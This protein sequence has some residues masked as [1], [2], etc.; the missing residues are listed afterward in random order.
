MQAVSLEYLNSMRSI[1]RDRGYMR[2][3]F[4]GE[5]AVALEYASII[6]EH[7]PYSNT[8]EVFNNGLDT[9]I[10]GTLEQD[11]LKI[12][13]SMYFDS[14]SPY[15]YPVGFIGENL[16]TTGVTQ[17]VDLT[18]GGHIVSIAVLS[19][20][21]GDNYPLNFSITDSNGNTYTYTNTTGRLVTITQDFNNITGLTLTATAMKND[22]S[23]LRIYSICFNYSF[24]YQNDKIIDSSFES[25]MSPISEHLPQINFSVE[26]IHENHEYDIENPASILT[27]FDRNT[28]VNVQYG[29]HLPESNTIE[30]LQAAKLYVK[31]WSVGQTSITINA[32][33]IL[34]LIDDK[35]YIYGQL[36]STS[37]YDLA[38]DLFAELGISNYDID[39]D[40]RE[41]YTKNPIPSETCKEGLQII[42]NAAGKKLYI[43]RD[44]SIKIGDTYYSTEIS[45]SGELA[46]SDTDDINLDNTKYTYATLEENF[47]KVDGSMYF[48]A[49][50]DYL[51]V[52]YVSS[53][54]S[55]ENKRFRAIS[56]D[57]DLSEEVIRGAVINL[58]YTLTIPAGETGM[59][60]LTI[61][62]T[63]GI[64]TT[65]NFLIRFSET[66]PT[67]FKVKGYYGDTLQYSELI[68]N[69]SL[70]CS[71]QLTNSI[72]INRLE[73][74]F[75]ETKEPYNRI[76]IAYIDIDD[77]IGAGVSLTFQDAMS[78]PNFSCLENVSR[79]VVPYF[80]YY[81]AEAESKLFEDIISG[82]TA[83]EEIEFA[84]S[85]P[86]TNYRCTVTTGTVTIVKSGAY[87]LTL[88]FSSTASKTLVIYGTK[89]EK[90]TRE[91]SEDIMTEGK[92]IRWENPLVD[93]ISM[94][95]NLLAHIKDYYTSK[96]IYKYNTR[97]NPEIDVN[98][99][100]LQENYRGE[101]TEV[102]ITDITLGFNGAF[103]GAVTALR[104]GDSE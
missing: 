93:R 38:E 100:M 4:G 67:E 77:H 54:I 46:Y 36:T 91:V 51:T 44:G 62:S 89:L 84:L 16:I 11:F 59:P 70:D 75:L 97:G 26:L 69:N 28:E 85:G 95:E 73:I 32:A 104:K 60:K 37:L 63:Q 41:I 58:P 98:D 90:V 82:N 74:Q 72:L 21:F 76:H 61:T 81:A 52:G 48:D 96:G 92:V 66:Y 50:S 10:Y 88:R 35:P 34:Q 7:L 64:F 43:R 23:R 102:V 45:N 9:Y 20:N 94:A 68:T 17:T 78:Y 71:V 47:T 13:G 27:Q 8:E 87:G 42:A 31:D 25:S 86:A 65:D 103:S 12:D 55:G 2:V 56:G 1:F 99:R 57:I 39:D 24:V 19:F 30:W 22:Q 29:Y 53:Q 18:F 83:N 14:V 15:L 5:N 80:S 33:D 3:S 40:L 6:G 101:Q 49:V 79:I